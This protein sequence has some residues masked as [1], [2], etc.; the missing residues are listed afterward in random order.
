MTSKNVKNIAAS[1]RQKL[2][3][4][5]KEE[6]RS[7]EELVRRYA[8]ERFLY[9]LSQ[10]EY[11]DKLILKG[12]LMFAVWKKSIYR[13]TMDI[14][15]LGRLNND[16]VAL[17]KCVR[18]IC[19]TEVTPDG[20]LFDPTSVKSDAITKD[21]DYVGRRIQFLGRMENMRIS[22][23]VDIGFGDTVFPAPEEIIMPS[24][25]QMPTG[26]IIGYT[27]ESAIAEKFHAMVQMAELNSRM[28]DFYD[29]WLLSS[30]FDFYGERLAQA[31]TFTFKTRNVSVEENVIAFSIDFAEEKQ[32]QWS[33]YLKKNRINDTSTRFRD[34]TYQ[35]GSFLLPIIVSIVKKSPPPRLWSAPG[36]WRQSL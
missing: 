31:I 34:I 13:P 2:L 9:R 21:A 12:A 22:M 25:F 16:S 23:Q 10:S 14:D 3:N 18:D 28:K 20:I 11:R 8:M 19:S 33:S 15:M 35:V 4:K 36:S 30:S 24:F 17:E 32:A 6:N 27:R 7:F 29:I 5:S 1:A 26:V